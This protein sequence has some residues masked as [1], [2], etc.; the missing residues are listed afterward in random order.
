MTKRRTLLALTA[1]VFASVAALAESGVARPGVPSS[2]QA[3]ERI[4][5]QITAI[6]E[7][8]GAHEVISDATVEG[9][10]G[11]DFNVNLED[12][13]FKMSARFMTDLAPGGGLGLR[14]GL[15]TRH[16][17]GYSEAGLP[18]YE[19]DTQRHTLALN[20]DEEVVLLPFGGGGS[21]GR[22]SIEITPART[23]R[24]ARTP[25]G[26]TTAPEITISKPSP[27]GIITVEAKKVP[28]DYEVEATLLDDG[29]EIAWGTVGCLLEES[30]RMPLRR[31][32]GSVPF[33]LDLKVERYEPDAGSGRVGLRFDLF[34]GDGAQPFERQPVARNWA[35]AAGVGSALSYDVSQFYRGGEGRRFELRLR[36]RLAQAGAAGR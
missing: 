27:G 6:V 13:G 8:K 35:G 10:P 5:F 18:L 29:R 14:V 23:G 36:A 25:S 16:F 9:P 24:Q 19:E 33:A 30:C 28:H 34:D 22:L 2:V 3:D 11:T 15:D 21:A 31:D 17:Y 32:D 20:F 1:L 4:R 26:E 12:R 7:S